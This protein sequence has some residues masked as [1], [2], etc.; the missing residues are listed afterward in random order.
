[1]EF[2]QA[3][4]LETHLTM[5]LFHTSCALSFH[6]LAIEE[7][8]SNTP[9]LSTVYQFYLRLLFMSIRQ[10]LQNKTKGNLVEEEIM[11]DTSDCKG[12]DHIPLQR[13][14]AT[15]KLPVQQE[16]LIMC[17]VHSLYACYLQN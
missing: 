12:I 11:N 3:L 1:M 5:P 8:G 6:Q 17:Q 14:S 15:K 4:Q 10:L 7:R 13:V 16:F 2:N 9:I